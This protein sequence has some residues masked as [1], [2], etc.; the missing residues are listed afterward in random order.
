MKES[1]IKWI[2]SLYFIQNENG[3]IF[4]EIIYE[5]HSPYWAIGLF[6]C[7]IITVYLLWLISRFILAKLVIAFV[8]K[9][10]ITWDDYF[11]KYKVF[12]SLANLVPLLLMEYFLSIVFYQ[13][14]LINSYCLRFAH[15]LI[16]FV[17]MISVNRCL[18][19]FR[20]IIQENIRYQDKPIQSYFQIAKITSTCIFIIMMLSVLTDQTPMFFV[21]SLGAMTAIVAL[22][23]KDT[24]LGFISSL[25][26]SSNDMVRIG[27]WITMDK[28]GADGDVIEIN[29]SSVKIRNFDKTIS[30]IPTYSFISDSFKNWR[31]MKES[32]GRRIKRSISLQIDSIAFASPELL[33][34]LRKVKIIKEFIIEREQEIEKY[35]K[36]FG[37]KDDDELNG[38][39]QTNIGLFRRYI[40]F[41]IRCNPHINKEMTIMIRQ[42]EAKET[43]VPIEIYCF[44]KVKEFEPYEAIVAD[45]FDHIFAVTHL[46]ELR[47][48]ENP[49]GHDFRLKN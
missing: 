6:I 7:L 10:T 15:L 37:F 28:F 27:D 47:I 25:Q 8:D 46:F 16:V 30:S 1:I 35:N 14:P 29:V 9:T 18:S 21:T 49:S 40:E 24:I 38:R 23:F 41:Y 39:R 42:L 34:R 33:E 45:I 22:V 5:N 20:D 36:E 43:G 11:V 13:Y 31:G 12:R 19:A 32:D 26:L 48:F 17:I 44:T 3:R 4:D 2:R